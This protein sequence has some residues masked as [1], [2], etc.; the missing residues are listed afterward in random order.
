MPRILPAS[1]FAATSPAFHPSSST[2]LQFAQMA[3]PWRHTQTQNEQVWGQAAGGVQP[4][5]DTGLGIL[6]GKRVLPV[7]VSL[8]KP[9]SW[10]RALLTHWLKLGHT[11]LPSSAPPRRSHG[12]SV[13]PP[14]LPCGHQGRVSGPG[15]PGGV[16]VGC[17]QR[18]PP[19]L[20]W[21]HAEQGRWLRAGT[22]TSVCPSSQ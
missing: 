20:R 19:V 17:Q 10:R 16:L 13:R 5:E 6:K 4:R 1:C 14:A 8:L 22:K 11:R 7:C 15:R 3:I 18:F 9:L 2:D 21:L 12:W